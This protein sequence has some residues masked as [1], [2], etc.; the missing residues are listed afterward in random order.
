MTAGLQ[1]RN[2]FVR[3]VA[4]MAG[5]AARRTSC[6]SGEADVLREE[7]GK[8]TAEARWGTGPSPSTAMEETTSGRP[9][10]S[11]GTRHPAQTGVPSHRA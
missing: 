8:G 11:R 9:P 4:R 1:P 10:P 5:V 6:T 7:T 2:R 3:E